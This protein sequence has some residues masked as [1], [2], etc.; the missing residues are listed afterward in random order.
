MKRREF[1]KKSGAVIATA[2]AAIA[3]EAFT[4]RQQEKA[5]NLLFITVDDM[6]HSVFG[7][8]GNPLS[9]TPNID[10]F[11]ATAHKFVNNRTTAPICQPSREA[12]MT[13]MVPHHSGALG[14][15]PVKEGTPTLTSLLGARGYYTVAMNKMEHM[16][17]PS[18]FPWNEASEK[19]GRKSVELG[20]S[21]GKAIHKS[22]Q[23]KKPFFIN[24]NILDP[25]RPFYGSQ[26]AA[27]I[28]HHETGPY[29]LSPLVNADEVQVPSFLENLPPIQTELTQYYN[30]VR[31]A[32]RSFGQ[33][34]RA[35]HESGESDNTVVIFSSDHGM[36]FPL[37]KATVYTNGIRTPTLLAWPRMGTPKSFEELTSNIDV[38]PTLLDILSLPIP[39][40][41]DGKSWVPLCR[42]EKQL[43]RDHVVAHVNSLH[44]TGSY[45]MRSFETKRFAL[46]FAPWS[47]GV[48]Q[49]KAESMEG[50]TFNAMKQAAK[51][52]PRIDERVKQYVFGRPLAFYDLEKDPDQRTDV[53]D[54]PEYKSAV[55]E[56]KY[57]L[58]TYMETT[59]DPQLE[60]F[61]IIL[62]DGKP[63]PNQFGM[64]KIT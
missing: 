6:N 40:N 25:H 22:K 38:L 36:P 48:L 21:V 26:E 37:S 31:R 18:C 29:Y 55:D 17:P 5:M 56:M 61:R 3:A 53:I 44:S 30:S 11:A 23:L 52:S 47:D 14:F 2:S 64:R 33:V 34:T 13:G 8:K 15:T 59:S 27:G 32:D 58:L 1:L 35:L 20:E 4:G 62:A 16:Q 41:V 45:P 49:F 57:R 60:N 39:K 43:G 7:W 24:C 19:N 46:L 63:D 42:G 54:V 51:T 12:M 50:L 9:L 10:A 28:D